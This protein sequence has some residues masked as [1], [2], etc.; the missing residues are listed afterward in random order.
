MPARVFVAAVLRP[1]QNGKPECW[2]ILKSVRNNLLQ[3]G[4]GRTYVGDDDF[5]AQQTTG[6]QQVARL[7]TKKSDGQKRWNGAQHFSGIAH[8]AARNIDG[9]DRQSPPGCGSQGFRGRSPECA[10]KPRAKDRVYHQLRPTERCGRQRFDGPAPS[11]CM[12][13]R[14]ANQMV[15]LTQQG[16]TNGPAGFDKMPGGDEAIAAVVTRPTQNDNGPR[17]PAPSDFACY[18]SAGTLHHIDGWYPGRDRQTIGLGHL[19]NTEQRRLAIHHICATF[20]I[21]AD[22][23]NR[24]GPVISRRSSAPSL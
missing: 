23:S 18:G 12:M 7:L 3:N 20:P 1:R 14:F 15:A 5:A 22:W 8:Q 2:I 19:A 21:E 11:L 6:Q 16:D 13:V 9:N 4:R 17:L 24:S 10:A